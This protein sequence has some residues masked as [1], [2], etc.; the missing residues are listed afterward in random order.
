MG[1]GYVYW[2]DSVQDNAGNYTRSKR[3]KHVNLCSGGK[4]EFYTIWILIVIVTKPCSSMYQ[5]GPQRKCLC[6]P[7]K[8]SILC[9][10]KDLTQVPEFGVG[11]ERYTKIYLQHNNIRYVD[12][13]REYK[14]LDICHNPVSCTQILPKWVV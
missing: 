9:V 8:E 10:G 14:I 7:S 1:T 5:C 3:K 13:H 4:M 11:F 6:L 2:G 12:I